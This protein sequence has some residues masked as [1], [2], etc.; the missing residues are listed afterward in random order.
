[1]SVDKVSAQVILVST[2]RAYCLLLGIL[3][4]SL[5]RWCLL[6]TSTDT[7]SLWSVSSP[8]SVSVITGD[9]GV[10]INRE[11]AKDGQKEDDILDTSPFLGKDERSL[12]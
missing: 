2:T 11:Y 8:L 9:N 4:T 10:V 5:C 12:L 3:Y 1:M 7:C 6:N